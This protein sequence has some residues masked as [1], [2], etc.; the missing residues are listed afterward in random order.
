MKIIVLVS[1][2][3]KIMRGVNSLKCHENEQDKDPAEKTC[4]APNNKFCAHV[5]AMGK[6]VRKCVGDKYDDFTV[7]A[8][9]MMINAM[10][11]K[12]TMC[13]CN[14]DNCNHECKPE[15]CPSE[16]VTNGAAPSHAHSTHHAASTAAP[17]DPKVS[18]HAHSPSAASPVT[19]S[20][21][22]EPARR[23]KRE[24]PVPKPTECAAKCKAPEGKGE[25]TDPEREPK[26]TTK[27]GSQRIAMPVKGF[28]ASLIVAFTITLFKLH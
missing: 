17:L 7:K 10:G 9:C 1:I 27:S 28:Y 24:I 13:F 4:E 8:G 21:E 25:E 23:G 14:T 26:E 3:L 19:P 5:D 11:M 22:T 20:K 2:L 15:G 18:T 12:T 6:V 16:E